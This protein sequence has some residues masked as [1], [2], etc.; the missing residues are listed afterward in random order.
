MR[1]VI[2]DLD[3]TLIDSA[4]FIVAAVEDAFRAAGESVPDE[5]AIRSISGIT[6]REGLAMLAPHASG[7]QIDFITNNYRTRY[8]SGA[9]LHSEPLFKGALA[10][11]DRLQADPEAILA[12]A[13]GKSYGG[14][15]T[16]LER[17]GLIDRF[18]SV[19]TPDHNRG[20]PDPQMI[21]TAMAKAGID[22]ESTVMI[23]DTV[24]DMRMAR[25]AKVGAI[26]VAW[27]YHQREE[28]LDAGADVV[29]E[30]F[31]ELDGVILQLTGAKDA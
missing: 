5:R 15:T 11:L 28:L 27:G 21:E 8:R 29:L 4:S 2:F 16:L 17:H 18:L 3:G 6:A 24:H 7:E 23:G 1:L 31:E 14:A 13:T 22:R 19:E 12:V 30:T 10:A 9:G 26:G 20:K 25:S